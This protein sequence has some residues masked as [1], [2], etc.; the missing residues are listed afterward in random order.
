MAMDKVNQICSI[1][2]QEE[3]AIK[4][5]IPNTFWTGPSTIQGKIQKKINFFTV[6]RLVKTLK[7]GGQTVKAKTNIT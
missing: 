7:R 4:T 6:E 5:W 3:T 2:L 1:G